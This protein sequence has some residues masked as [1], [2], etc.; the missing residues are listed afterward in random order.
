MRVTYIRCWEWLISYVA[1]IENS[2]QFKKITHYVPKTLVSGLRMVYIVDCIYQLDRWA[3]IMSCFDQ[4]Q[5]A[6]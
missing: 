4:K 6:A 2:G 3:I 1:L 5:N